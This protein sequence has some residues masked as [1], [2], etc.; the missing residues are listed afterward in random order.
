MMSNLLQISVSLL[1]LLS[2][3]ATLFAAAA[4]EPEEIWHEL[5]KLSQD[6]RQ[7]RLIAGAKAEGKAVLYGNISSDHV[8]RL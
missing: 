3:S 7:K 4:K 5:G 8:E 6:E 2:F 1:M